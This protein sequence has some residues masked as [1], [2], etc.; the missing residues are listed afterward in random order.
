MEK[1]R[2]I[3]AD[4]LD[5]L[6]VDAHFRCAICPEHR[7]IRNIHH[8]VPF[9]KNGPNSESNLIVVCPNCHE[10]I[11]RNPRVYTK[12]RVKMAKQK[13]ID[14]C[15]KSSL[16]LQEKIAQS[17]GIE[18]EKKSPLIFIPHPYPE[19]PNF[20]GRKKE[21]GAMLTK[22]LLEDTE[23]PLLSMVAIGGMG[24]SA[25][26]W[27][28]L[29][30]DVIGK[31]VEFDGIVWWSFYE[32]EATF[33]AFINEMIGILFPEKEK[34]LLQRSDRE[35]I[36]LILLEF[37]RNNFLIVFDGFERTLRAYALAGLSVCYIGDEYQK[38]IGEKFRQCLDLNL[39]Q[40]I[41]SLTN[42]QCKTKMIMTTR[43]HPL[44]LRGLI[45]VREEE[46]TKIDSNEAVEFF[47]RQGV[48]GS[49]PEIRQAC[50]KYDF[51]PLC[52]RLL[53]GVLI[54]SQKYKGDIKYVKE[55]P[56]L[57]LTDSDE[58]YKDSKKFEHIL[59]FS[60]DKLPEEDKA[61]ISGIAAFRSPMEFEV[62]R[63]IFGNDGDEDTFRGKLEPLERRGLLFNDIEK[64]CYDLHPIVRRYCYGRLTAP[65]E[66]HERI[67]FYF[68]RKVKD[69]FGELVI[70]QKKWLIT[71]EK[72]KVES[73][74]EIELVIELYH[75]TI[76]TGRYDE[77]W[78][79][80]RDRLLI[81]VYYHL[82]DFNK[83]IE[84]LTA[85]FGVDSE[86]PKLKKGS[87]IAH[88]CY[89]LANAYSTS[90]KPIEA[91][92][93]YMK[94]SRLAKRMK[95]QRYIGRALVN[96][97]KRM[98]DIGDF[99]SAEFN[100]TKMIKISKIINMKFDEAYGHRLLSILHINCAE[101]EK[102]IKEADKV[103]KLVEDEAPHQIVTIHYYQALRALLMNQPKKAVKT[104]N[105][106][107]ILAKKWEE[108]EYQ[109]ASDF[110]WGHKLI[111]AS[112]LV[113][114]DT[115]EAES[116]LNF[117]LTECR[118]YNLIKIEA[119]VLLELSRLNHLLSNE[120]ESLN[121]ATEALEI[122]NRCSYVLQ[123]A[124]IHLF[125]GEYYRDTDDLELAREHA[126]LAK[127]RSHQMVDVET[128][129]Y[130]TKDEGT[131]WKYKPCYD[132]AK[133]LLDTL[134]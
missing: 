32:R 18:L 42:P 49:A 73:T 116:H 134:S 111:G 103:L 79:L 122:A 58:Y 121:L 10:S 107:L 27:R 21:R 55:I 56:D 19:A 46:L 112:Y 80:Y 123:Q 25:L 87:Y 12:K 29:Q 82:R 125:L 91:A 75:H 108:N 24:K 109:V 64:D 63:T 69:K 76:K 81:A 52:L 37:T 57:V 38:G 16:S 62:L 100:I 128:G 77:A 35:K 51:L 132:K 61:L 126:G 50:A 94:A 36:D 26:T 53:S 102:S 13:W 114:N 1:S 110:I 3:P 101:Y 98:I 70:P 47:H 41:R 59:Q 127:L 120:K 2:D 83:Q 104:A 48:K 67:R 95:Q 130:I 44:D 28:W 30:E 33:Q 106:A 119:V 60:Y 7:D 89:E 131:K 43:L 34:E 4:V 93:L 72:G 74:Q 54:T 17:P 99:K 115:K 96:L 88:C 14:I 84:C 90:G 8:I 22:W 65:K 92:K 5:K 6:L 9:R 66:T 31:G 23:H 20:T 97:A 133:A 85:L 39:S 71:P 129:D 105:D 68:N 113:M 117:A 45:G 40:F 78:K 118:K 11:H 15:S 124:D 86:L